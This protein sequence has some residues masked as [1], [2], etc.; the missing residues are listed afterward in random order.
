MAMPGGGTAKFEKFEKKPAFR[1]PLPG[2]CSSFMRLMLFD[3]SSSDLPRMFD[4]LEV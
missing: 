1:M 3:E 4:W 2:I